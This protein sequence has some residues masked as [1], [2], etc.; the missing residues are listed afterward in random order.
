MNPATVFP[1]DARR[2]KR[3]SG[4]SGGRPDCPYDIVILPRAAKARRRRGR[5]GLAEPGGALSGLEATRPAGGR[6]FASHFHYAELSSTPA[7][8]RRREPAA[9]HLHHGGQPAQ[10]LE[11]QPAHGREPQRLH[12]RHDRHDARGR[13]RLRQGADP[14]P[15]ARERGRAEPHGCAER[16]P[17]ESFHITP[18]AK[19]NADLGGTREPTRR[20]SGVDSGAFLDQERPGRDDRRP[21][22]ARQRQ[23]PQPPRRRHRV[24]VTFNTPLGQRRRSMTRRASLPAYCG[25][26]VYSDLHVG[27]A[28]GD[29]VLA[30]QSGV[31]NGKLGSSPGQCANQ[32]LSP[33]EKALEFMLF[34]LSSCVTRRTT[35]LARGPAGRRSSSSDSRHA[36]RDREAEDAGSGRN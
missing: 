21:S 2:A 18:G 5:G 6:V 34:D 30:A 4:T 26:V 1:A 8:S 35:G 19:H 11:Q 22:T 33:Q 23:D 14:R 16:A 36:G 29:Y 15:V 9:R 32:P 7:R 20:S 13:R 27:S 25:R 10:R 24:P 12:Q 31:A 3:R 17:G 28:S